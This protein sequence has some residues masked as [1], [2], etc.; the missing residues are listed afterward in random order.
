ML[1]ESAKFGRRGGCTAESLGSWDLPERT[2]Q[3]IEEL[4][5]FG[6]SQKTWSSYK[7]GDKIL[8]ELAQVHAV[9]GYSAL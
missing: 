2:K 9:L 3:T 1:R 7:T 8:R 4:G 5:N 6:L